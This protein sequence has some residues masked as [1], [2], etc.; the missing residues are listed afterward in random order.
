[1]TFDK[2]FTD[3]KSDEVWF[4]NATMHHKPETVQSVAKD[5][6]MS[7]S[8]DNSLNRPIGD[9]RRYFWNKLKKITPD[10][11]AK[12]WV[13]K[14]E[15]KES[16][17]VVPRESKEYMDWTNKILEEIAK[18][19]TINYFPGKSYSELAD[20]GGVRRPKD[21]PYPMTSQAEAYVRQ[22]HLEY[23]K[24]NYE[25]RTGAKLPDWISEDEFNQLYDSGLI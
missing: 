20:E 9:M 17:P 1:M 3:L 2:F 15:K 5:L 8:A 13:P 24:R 11:V 14:E 19:K 6:F 7:C 16:A 18:S 22:R 4:C 12:Q 21:K 25:P 10:K 23:I